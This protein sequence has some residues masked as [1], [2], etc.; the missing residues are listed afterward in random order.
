VA[1]IRYESR[2]DTIRQGSPKIRW[3]SIVCPVPECDFDLSFRSDTGSENDDDG[4]GEIVNILAIDPGTNQSGY[5]LWSTLTNR[6]EH[7]DILENNEMLKRIHGLNDRA[8]VCAIE[9]IGHY[10]TGMPA[11]KEVFETCIWIGRF[12]QTFVRPNDVQL[13][14]RATI[15]THLCGSARAKDGNVSQALRDRFGEKGT[16]ANP[17]P[18]YGVKSH[19]WQACA[20]AVYVADLFTLDSME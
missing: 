12:Q 7:F 15:K 8:D 14:K 2:R 17:G 16:K 9:M 20:L 18:F 10:G 13:I 4:E 6:P 5:V 19:I 1:R 3:R 11:G